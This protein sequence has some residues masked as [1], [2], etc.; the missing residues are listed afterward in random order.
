M[1]LSLNKVVFLI[2]II[3]VLVVHWQARR[4]FRKQRAIVQKYKLYAIRDRLIYLV[5]SRQIREDDPVLAYFYNSI[6]FVIK[7]TEVLNLRSLVKALSDLRANGLNP[8]DV[9]MLESLNCE[10]QKKPK[11]LAEVV[12]EFYQT[13]L[14]ILL[15]NSLIMRALARHPWLPQTALVVKGC[16]SAAFKLFPPFIAY[17][18]YKE[19]RDAAEHTTGLHPHQMAA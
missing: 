7:N 14:Q 4:M 5:A 15:E 9:D 13:V 1:N 11:D 17:K 19:Y 3:G 16:L 8:A 12:A 18:F 10:L 2:G 6:T